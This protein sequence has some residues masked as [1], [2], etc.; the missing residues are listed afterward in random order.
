MA[1]MP[2]DRIPDSDQ[3]VCI[4]P[5]ARGNCF[6]G[7]SMAY[8][9]SNAAPWKVL[10]DG[11]AGPRWR[12]NIQ[13]CSVWVSIRYQQEAEAAMVKS[14]AIIVRL[15]SWRSAQAPAMGAMEDVGSGEAP[16]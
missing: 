7:T 4:M 16:G 11:E 10:G 5:L 8:E 12:I 6:S 13:S 3:M 14:V 1:A 9:V 2:G 15:R